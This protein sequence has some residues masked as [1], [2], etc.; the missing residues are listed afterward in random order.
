MGVL[1]FHHDT[2]QFR[3]G[4]YSNCLFHHTTI[5]CIYFTK[6]DGL[7]ADGSPCFTASPMPTSPKMLL[8]DQQFISS[9][10][11]HFCR[12]APYETDFWLAAFFTF[13]SSP[14]RFL[15]AAAFKALFD[16]FTGRWRPYL[17]IIQP[18]MLRRPAPAAI[19]CYWCASFQL[20]NADTQFY[21]IFADIFMRFQFSA[22]LRA[23][24]YFF[25]LAYYCLLI[26]FHDGIISAARLIIRFTVRSILQMLRPRRRL[27]AI[28]SPALFRPHFALMRIRAIFDC[29]GIAWHY[30][31]LPI[32]ILIILLLYTAITCFRPVATNTK[33]KQISNIISF[34][35]H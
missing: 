7:D 18:P 21:Y 6:P 23:R 8:L 13:F 19:H 25:L 32:L 3:P 5:C 17:H 9:P 29:F 11:H 2:Q 28:L 30:I 20:S 31:K 35:K 12:W 14:R 22:A 1:E 34:M 4:I 27:S 16:S 15:A 10:A 33:S 26:R 24:P